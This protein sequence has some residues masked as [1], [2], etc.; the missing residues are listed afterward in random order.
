MSDMHLQ[1]KLRKITEAAKNG[2]HIPERPKK[3][4][5]LIF[6]II[7]AIGLLGLAALAIALAVY[8]HRLSWINYFP[9]CNLP[10]VCV[11]QINIGGK[12]P[13]VMKSDVLTGPETI[14]I[15]V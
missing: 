4:G 10:Y 12:Y 6:F 9:Y 3:V 2:E 13:F 8:G 15:I 1:N 7:S 5:M 14:V 11:I